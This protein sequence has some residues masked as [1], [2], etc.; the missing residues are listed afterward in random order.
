MQTEKSLR[1]RK[2]EEPAKEMGHKVQSG[3]KGMAMDVQEASR[4]EL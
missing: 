1:F 4:I 3:K 2:M